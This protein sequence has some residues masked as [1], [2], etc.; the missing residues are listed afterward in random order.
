MFSESIGIQ[1]VQLLE[2]VYRHIGLDN[3]TLKIRLPLKVYYMSHSLNTMK[4]SKIPPSD[5]RVP[6][7]AEEI[8]RAAEQL[9]NNLSPDISKWRAEQLKYTAQ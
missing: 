7:K 3:F 4:I 6:R 2:T 9:R 1:S 5:I 8:S